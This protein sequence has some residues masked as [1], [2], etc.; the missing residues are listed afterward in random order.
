[1]AFTALKNWKMIFGPDQDYVS[2]GIFLAKG[3]GNGSPGYP[4]LNSLNGLLADPGFLL[5]AN[6]KGAMKVADLDVRVHFMVEKVDAVSVVVGDHDGGL[7][8]ISLVQ[9]D[10]IESSE[11][12]GNMIRGGVAMMDMKISNNPDINKLFKGY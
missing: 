1:M 9:T 10:S 8:I 2:E 7:K 3:E 11:P 5:F 12:M 6:V 4:I